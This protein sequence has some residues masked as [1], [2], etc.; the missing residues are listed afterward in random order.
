MN[1]RRLKKQNNFFLPNI[2]NFILIQIK[3]NQ[4]NYFI[5]FSLVGSQLYIRR[6]YVASVAR[7][8]V[9]SAV[10]IQVMPVSYISQSPDSSSG[11]LLHLEFLDFT[12]F[13]RYFQEYVYLHT[14]H[15]FQSRIFLNLCKDSQKALRAVLGRNTSLC[16]PREPQTKNNNIQSIGSKINKIGAKQRPKIYCS[17]MANYSNG[18]YCSLL[19]TSQSFWCVRA[20]H[21]PRLV[22]VKFNERQFIEAMHPVLKFE[23]FRY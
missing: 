14:L 2:F 16:L 20:A 19:P 11:K 15:V 8:R 22:I 23:Q 5:V 3:C 4:I 6:Y 10:F 7:L 13:F 9:R 1:F 17:K 21:L 18:N 12:V